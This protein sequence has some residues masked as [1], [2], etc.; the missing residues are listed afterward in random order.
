MSQ[1]MLDQSK[2]VAAAHVILAQDGLS[3]EL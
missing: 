2:Q 3:L 1:A